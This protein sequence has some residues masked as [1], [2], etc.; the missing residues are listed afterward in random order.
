V[1]KVDDGSTTIGDVSLLT[2]I[3]EKL[4]SSN[5]IIPALKP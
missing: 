1:M 3:A 2:R 5:V 4:A